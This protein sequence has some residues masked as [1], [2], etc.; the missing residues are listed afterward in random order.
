MAYTKKRTAKS[1]AHSKNKKNQKLQETKKINTNF[2]KE[3]RYNIY[4]LYIYY[5]KQKTYPM[6]ARKWLIQAPKEEENIIY[7]N[8]KAEEGNC[9]QTGQDQKTPTSKSC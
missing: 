5:K 7:L 3:E 4:I 1:F 2:Y 8:I 6:Q 9:S